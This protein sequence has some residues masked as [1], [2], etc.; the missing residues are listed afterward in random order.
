M[1]LTL[2]HYYFKEIVY[3]EQ[4]RLADLLLITRAAYHAD[5]VDKLL[6][7]LRQHPDKNEQVDMLSVD[8]FIQ[9]LGMHGVKVKGR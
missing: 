3:L 2:V 1:P 9:M 4:K 6:A 5:K 8:G 7:Q